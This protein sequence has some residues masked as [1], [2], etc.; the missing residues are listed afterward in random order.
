MLTRMQRLAWAAFLPAVLALV[1]AHADEP[2]AGLPPPPRRAAPASDAVLFADQFRSLE[3]WQPD[4]AGVWTVEDGVLCARLPDEKQK[5][6]FLY[7]GSEDW[8]DYA[9]DLDLCQLRG[10]DKGVVVR[11]RDGSGVGV[12]LRGGSYQDLMLYRQEVPL[13]RAKAPNADRAWHHLRVEARGSRYV[14][15][16]DGERLLDRRDPLGPG[17]HGRIA[18]VAYTGGRGE[19][20]VR[21]ANVVVTKLD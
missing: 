17:G 6:S 16:V 20:T 10:V 7:A 14:V 15:L 18:L 4:R 8:Q 13:G 1:P 12:D 2:A 11:V 9:L 3:A 19:C 21:Y 5:R